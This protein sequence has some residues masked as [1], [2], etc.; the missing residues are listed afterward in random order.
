MEYLR[1]V[2]I[3]DEHF[4]TDGVFQEAFFIG[5]LIYITRGP[6][7]TSQTPLWASPQQYLSH[8]H[9]AS[10]FSTNSI[11]PR[12]C[13]SHNDEHRSVPLFEGLAAGCSAVE[14]D[15]WLSPSD[16]TT[17][18][19]GHDPEDLDPPRSLQSLYLDPLLQILQGRTAQPH[20]TGRIYEKPL[21]GPFVLMLDFKSQRGD[22][23]AT[24]AALNQELA[25]LRE[26]GFLTYCDDEIGQRVESALVIVA[27][28]DCPF[29]ALT[30]PPYTVQRDIFFDAPLR[31]IW[32]T[33]TNLP[34]KGR[35]PG[36]GQGRAGTANLTDA[37][38][39]DAGNSYMASTS[40]KAMYWP[41]IGGLSKWQKSEM[42]RQ[43]AAARAKG[44]KVR[45][46]G[47]FEEILGRWGRGR[48]WRDLEEVDVDVW[49]V[50]DLEGYKTGKWR[51]NGSWEDEM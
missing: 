1:L 12:P 33:Q 45:Y 15:I 23:A 7:M 29:D 30:S 38:V 48:L 42:K 46:W 34:Q 5:L 40:F 35:E 50:D 41:P 39:F 4:F 14:A 16:N 11:T 32:E 37:D 47:T 36:R 27:S 9:R 17:L 51:A 26:A 43:V 49:N 13:I 6:R 18:L 24:L 20:V 44:L 22:G 10:S 31:W 8:T 21:P 25:P 28:G 19:I 2:T 3:A